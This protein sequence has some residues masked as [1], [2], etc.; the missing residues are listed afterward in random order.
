MIMLNAERE[1]ADKALRLNGFSDL[2]NLKLPNSK[3]TLRIRRLSF[4][5]NPRL[6]GASSIQRQLMDRE[7]INA[8]KALKLNS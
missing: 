3:P 4:V 2:N 5:N 6:K 8:E 7:R 1:R